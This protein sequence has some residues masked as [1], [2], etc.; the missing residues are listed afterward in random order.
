MAYN[1]TFWI[2]GET[3]LNAENLNHI[4]EG[5]ESVSNK[6]NSNFEQINKNTNDIQKNAIDIK[7]NQN[8]SLFNS[9]RLNILEAQIN[10]GKNTIE[11][12]SDKEIEVTCN[13]ANIIDCNAHFKKI[14]GVTRM[15][16]LNLV[17]SK[18]T[19]V[20]T[21]RNLLNPNILTTHSTNGVTASVKGD[22]LTLKGTATDDA[23]FKRNVGTLFPTGKYRLSYTPIRGRANWEVLYLTSDRNTGYLGGSDQVFSLNQLDTNLKLNIKV[24]RGTIIDCDVK[25]MF[26]VGETILPYEPY[27]ESKSVINQ[28]LGAFDYIENGN[29]IKQTSE[30]ITLNGS[31]D[32]WFTEGAGNYYKLFFDP[33]ISTTGQAVCN[34]LELVDW[35]VVN[36]TEDAGTFF[37]SNDSILINCG[38]QNNVAKFKQWLAQNPI[39]LVYKK[40]TPTITPIN[41]PNGIVSYKNGLTSQETETIPYKYTAKYV[42]GGQQ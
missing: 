36:S 32:G 3:K 40:S 23:Y 13:G 21:G 38:I 39:T 28:E 24:P 34:M 10:A 27:I 8:F 17:N 30:M 26:N 9:D 11:Y 37:I 6:A 42:N 20:S 12:T 31:E 14:Q 33:Q 4:E 1:K 41:V 22:L 29:L 15:K 35:I 25:L 5:I 2:D 18:A 16:G 19:F 7:T